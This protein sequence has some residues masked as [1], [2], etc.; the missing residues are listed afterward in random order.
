[1][2]CFSNTLNFFG[3]CL[4]LLQKKLIIIIV[5]IAVISIVILELISYSYSQIEISFNDLS[6]V[7]IKLENL[8]L[9]DLIKLSLDALSGNWVSAALGVISE[10]DLGF[11][12]ELR[13]NGFFPVYVPDLS[14]DLSIND[15]LVGHG[16]SK[17]DASINPGM[18]KEIQVF[19]NIQK[20]SL[21]P[22]IESVIATDGIA[23]VRVN[24]TANF[25]LFGQIIQVPFD[26]TQQIS[27]I[28]EIQNQIAQQ[29]GD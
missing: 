5:I 3:F 1:M 7:E 16:Y 27:V 23:D 25:E 20:N 2:G 10:I 12:F 14:Y 19:Q 24:G 18:T 8:S 13:N 28:D 15:I 21:S 29:I 4:G 26:S 9:S 6:S 22:A 11:D 17:I